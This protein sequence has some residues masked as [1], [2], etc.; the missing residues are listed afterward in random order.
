MTAMA[1]GGMR[2]RVFS[3][4]LALALAAAL[5]GCNTVKKT[6]DFSPDPELQKDGTYPNI[7][8]EIGRAHV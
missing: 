2:R 8:V 5:S 7:N 6:F 3:L 1:D 4:G